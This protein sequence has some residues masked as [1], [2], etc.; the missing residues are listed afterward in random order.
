MNWK[1]A[2][3]EDLRRYT[4][5]KMALE[6]IPERVKM[7]EYRLTAMKGSMRDTD[8]VQGGMSMMEDKLL[9]NIVEKERLKHTYCA[10]KKLVD[11][12]S[13]GLAGLDEPEK[14][15]L[16][17]FYINR[18]KNHVE[19]LMEECNY[20]KSQVYN[21]KDKALY[22]FTISMYGLVDY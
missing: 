12:I 21:I 16:E 13:K 2:A 18:Q 5:Q 14:H 20:E 15:V 4:S 19:R 6:N 9:D 3:E 17:L 10:A 7:I 1:R 8:P 22:K 11:L